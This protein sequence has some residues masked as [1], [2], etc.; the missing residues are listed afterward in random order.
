MG[1]G[2]RLK[3]ERL[4]EKL[5]QIRVALGLSQNELVRR[6]GLEGEITYTKISHY[7]LG[8]REPPLTV[9]LEYARIANVHVEALIDDLIDLPSELPSRKKHVGTVKKPKLRG[10]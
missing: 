7:E 8:R 1:T 9:L 2:A 3:P 10:E 4:A 5:R 6:L